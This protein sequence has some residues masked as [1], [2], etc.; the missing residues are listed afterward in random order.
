MRGSDNVQVEAFSSFRLEDR[1]PEDHPLRPLKLICNQILKEMT[2]EFDAM[3]KEGGRPSIPPEQLIRALLLQVLFSVRSERQLMEQVNYN[4][5]FRWFIGLEMDDDVWVPTTFSHNRERLLEKDIANKFFAQVV[6]HADEQGLLS[7]DHFTVDGTL[8]TAWASLKSFKPRE[9]PEAEPSEDGPP[10]GRNSDVDYRGEK[11]SNQTHQSTTDAEA[12]LARKGPG[13]EARLSF[14][15]HLLS[16]NRHG[17]IVG[18]LVTQATGT[19]ERDAAKELIGGIA[20]FRRITVGADKG[21][22][23]KEFVGSLRDLKVTPHVAQKKANSAIDGRTTH[24][25]GYAVSQRKRKLVEEPFGWG[26]TVGTMARVRHRGV[27]LVNWMFLLNVAAY[28]LIRIVNLTRA[29]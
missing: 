23:T 28:D 25:A 11:R 9:Q 8:L 14:A 13:K 22:D 18:A 17:L 16:E 24:H 7:D 27:P 4:L 20:G 2:K 21:Y 19:A 15:G 10:S 26:K 6:A 12:M 1:I 3:Y 5:L 29:T